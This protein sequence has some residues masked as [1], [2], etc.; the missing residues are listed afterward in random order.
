MVEHI[1]TAPSIIRPDQLVGQAK[2]TTEI[3]S[4][5]LLAE[6]AIWTALDDEAIRM[7]G[8]DLASGAVAL[9]HQCPAERESRHTGLFLQRICRRQAGNAA[10]DDHN[11]GY[12]GAHTAS[13]GVRIDRCT[14]STS[15]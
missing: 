2:A 6:E 8:D 10:A 14:I 15:A 5:G 11:M 1:D 7:I 9:L 4:P 3:G 13:A 12:I